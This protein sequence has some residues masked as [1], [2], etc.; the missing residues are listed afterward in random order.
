[1]L[2][3]WKRHNV[4]RFEKIAIFQAKFFQ[5]RHM[6]YDSGESSI[7]P[8]T[9]S[10]R[11]DA[12]LK[13]KR[14]EICRKFGNRKLKKKKIVSKKFK[15]NCWHCFT[16][17]VQSKQIFSKWTCWINGERSTILL[18][19]SLKVCR[20]GIGR[21]SIFS[22]EQS[23]LIFIVFVVMVRCLKRLNISQTSNG[24][25]MKTA[26]VQSFLSCTSLLSCKHVLEDNR[27][28]LADS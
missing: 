14:S 19:I 26:C 4:V 28:K 21:S 23:P 24:L 20:F 16:S 27:I 5:L 2:K 7:H 13:R 11:H 3:L 25:D 10:S 8:T 6:L 22:L 15:R 1:M 12:I 9:A 17:F 18:I